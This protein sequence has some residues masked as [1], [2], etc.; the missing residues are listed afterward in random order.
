MIMQGFRFIEN[1][2][3]ATME[4]VHLARGSAGASPSQNLPILKQA[5]AL[6]IMGPLFFYRSSVQRKITGSV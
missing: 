4:N 1:G 6:V 2:S 3:G 5:K